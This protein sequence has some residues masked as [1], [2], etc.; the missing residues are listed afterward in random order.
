MGV[1]D[2]RKPFHALLGRPGA[3][4]NPMIWDGV[5]EIKKAAPHGLLEG[6]PYGRCMARS[7]SD[8]GLHVSEYVHHVARLGFVLHVCHRA[9]GE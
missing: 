9:V 4:T 6:C 2:T 1:P 3:I 8:D 7:V 5:G